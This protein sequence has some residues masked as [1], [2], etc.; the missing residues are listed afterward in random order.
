MRNINITTEDK[1]FLIHGLFYHYQPFHLTPTEAIL[2]YQNLAP[3]IQQYDRACSEKAENSVYVTAG[4]ENGDLH[5]VMRQDGER[6]DEGYLF[7]VS[8][9]EIMR[10]FI[11]NN[12]ERVMQ[13]LN[14]SSYSRVA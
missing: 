5:F 3:I 7:F 9:Q 13:L 14:K 1:W 8:F 6:K 10:N 12:E 2:L 11:R 4:M